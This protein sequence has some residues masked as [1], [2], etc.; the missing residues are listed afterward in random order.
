VDDVLDVAFA[1][2]VAG[3]RFAGKDELDGALRVFDQFQDV[4]KL[5]EDQRRPFVGG[6]AAGEPDGERVRVE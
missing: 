1:F 6:K 2:V 4:L 3:M 5:L